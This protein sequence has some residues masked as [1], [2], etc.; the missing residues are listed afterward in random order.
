MKSGRSE[1]LQGRT[2]LVYGAAGELMDEEYLEE[3]TSGVANKTARGRFGSFD[4]FGINNNTNDRMRGKYRNRKRSQSSSDD[5]QFGTGVSTGYT[6][7]KRTSS[8]ES[9]GN[10]TGAALVRNR[11]ESMESLSGFF[12]AFKGYRENGPKISDKYRNLKRNQNKSN[13]NY[14][15]A[16]LSYGIDQNNDEKR[17]ISTSVT[18]S[19]QIIREKQS[20]KRFRKERLGSMDV[21]YKSGKNQPLLTAAGNNRRFKSSSW[22][23]CSSFEGKDENY[24][25]NFGHN[26]EIQY[27]Y[28][29]FGLVT[30]SHK[31]EYFG[32]FR[33]ILNCGSTFV[34]PPPF[35]VVSRKIGSSEVDLPLK[36][37][38]QMDLLKGSL[39]VIE[40]TT[41]VS[42]N[43]KYD[44]NY[45][46]IDEI[47]IIFKKPIEGGVFCIYKKG[48]PKQGPDW[49]EHTF[50]SAHAAAQFQ[51]DLLVYQVLGKPFRQIFEALHLVHQGGISCEGQEFVLH[52]KIRGNADN[53]AEKDGSKIKNKPKQS[54]ET[55]H[56][57]AWDDAMR[58]MSSI[59]T[60]RIAL[61]RLWLSHNRP[62][63]IRS[64]VTKTAKD[65][66]KIALENEKATS[67]EM[68]LIKEEY[69]K[70]RLL[71]GPVDFYRLFVPSL[72]ETAIPE[73]DFNNRRRMEQ[74]LCWRKR[75]ARAS[76]LVR[77][78]TRARLVANQGWSLDCVL[79]PTGTSAA[80]DSLATGALGDHGG[81]QITKR[82]AYDGNENNH[83]R[84]INA[85]N[86]IYEASVSRDVLC[87]V[88]SFDYLNSDV[89]GNGEGVIEENQRCSDYY[90]NSSDHY[91]SQKHFVLSPYQAYTYVESHY[92]KATEDMLGEGGALHP[93]RDPIEIF[94]S[95][96][97][98]LVRHPDL[99]FFVDCLSNAEEKILIVNLHVRSLAKGIDTQFDN[100]VSWILFKKTITSIEASLRALP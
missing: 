58:A 30:L 36:R 87:H 66:S 86:E 76:V 89:D 13:N 34:P 61:E 78:Y 4:F 47:S 44:C 31:V 18:L 39:S 5:Y 55:T 11:S 8:T 94:P 95:L 71:L 93:S 72:P 100:V 62:S 43:K 85:K 63:V 83:L 68:S 64:K 98:I 91:H 52:D 65:K 79:P 2:S 23:D 54:M 41:S 16:R 50:E 56:F 6:T 57:V 77:S 7:R 97:E 53:K 17:N 32:P 1:I 45:D 38:I 21:Y 22:G 82:F 9:L 10:P 84:D 69:I 59:P 88:R 3:I 20:S 49:K 28:D 90:G 27:L 74:L 46:N 33:P 24:F 67:A 19:N 75:V 99:D 80:A 92:F 60:V 29:E 51:L 73:G 96:K 48:T 35:E 40:P 81:E 70:N 25:K 15:M 42:L 37:M 26:E 12:Q 14:K